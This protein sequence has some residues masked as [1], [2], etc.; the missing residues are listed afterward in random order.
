MRKP[1][2]TKQAYQQLMC[3]QCRAGEDCGYDC[4]EGSSCSFICADC[5]ERVWFMGNIQDSPT[6]C[7]CPY[8]GRKQSPFRGFERRK[9]DG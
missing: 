4:V 8:C 1:M 2:T 9:N 5:K 7:D 6:E 3:S